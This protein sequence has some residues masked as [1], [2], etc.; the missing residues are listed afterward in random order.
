MKP[1]D[2]HVCSDAVQSL[3][4]GH[5]CRG[6][7]DKAPCDHLLL[8]PV[9]D[10]ITQGLLCLGKLSIFFHRSSSLLGIVHYSILCRA[11]EEAYTKLCYTK[12][13]SVSSN[14][15]IM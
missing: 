12:N 6:Y 9:V 2:V 13:I 14:S 15:H 3:Q 1:V 11:Q 4:Q 10:S 5:L 8:Q 7:R